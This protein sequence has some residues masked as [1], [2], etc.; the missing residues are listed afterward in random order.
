MDYHADILPAMNLRHNNRVGSEG[1]L[2]QIIAG[3]IERSGPI[4]FARYM[5]LALYHPELGYYRARD[6]F[7]KQGDFYTAEQLQPVFGQ[8]VSHFVDKLTKRDEPNVP[9]EVLEIGAG[10]AEMARALTRWNYRAFDW[11]LPFLPAEWHGLILANEFFDALP[12]H[13]LM[14]TAQ[15]WNELY[16]GNS[17]Q[18]LHF[19]AGELS[20]T[21]LAGYAETYGV[22]AGVGGRL[23]A[24]LVLKAWC[25]RLS[26][27]LV[28]GDLLVIDYGYEPRELLRFPQGSLMTY[29]Y[30]R[31]SANLLDQPGG[32]DITAH[33]N[34]GW[35]RACAES[36]GFRFHSSSTLSGWLLSVW[37]ESELQRR[38]MQAD[39]R[40]KLQWKQ[41]LFRLG[42]TFTVL[43]FE[44]RRD[45]R[46]C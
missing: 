24:C 7:G 22:Q 39:E 21:A 6:P 34:F 44:K 42:E 14:K 1:E 46:T 33:V 16:V 28:D 27:L 18:G 23:E 31:A 26:R 4:T 40:W 32:R 38:W 15:S 25:D 10:R 11:N 36:A 8:V 41:L 30:H 43:R 45:R 20:T 19:S 5:E 3:E 13:L 17:S 9:Y 29:K 37:D 35:L 12:V 2:Q